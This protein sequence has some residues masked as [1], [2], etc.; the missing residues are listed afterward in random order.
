[1]DFFFRTKSHQK[2]V[3]KWYTPQ[4]PCPQH[5]GGGSIWEGKRKGGYVAPLKVASTFVVELTPLKDP[6]HL[7][8]QNEKVSLR[9]TG[10]GGL[11]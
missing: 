8:Y 2:Q 9:T 11:R 6:G 7:K 10:V 3:S 4:L 1:M 5:W